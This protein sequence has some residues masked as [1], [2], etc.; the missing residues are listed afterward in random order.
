[1]WKVCD[2]YRY[3]YSYNEPL[4]LTKLSRWRSRKAHLATFWS[5]SRRFL[6]ARMEWKLFQL[7]KSSLVLLI[8]RKWSGV[9]EILA[10]SSEILACSFLLKVELDPQAWGWRCQEISDPAVF[11]PLRRERQILF[12]F[13]SFNEKID[14]NVEIYNFVKIRY[15]Y[16]S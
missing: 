13:F 2:R 12:L 3:G 1:M 8:L 6:W 7:L 5:S 15:F 11:T 14:W 10:C 9:S 4:G 16:L